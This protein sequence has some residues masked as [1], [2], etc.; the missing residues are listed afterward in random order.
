M[1]GGRLSAG[2]VGYRIGGILPFPS[3]RRSLEIVTPSLQVLLVMPSETDYS[4]ISKLPIALR[5][6]ASFDDAFNRK[7]VGFKYSR[8]PVISATTTPAI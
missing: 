5:S 3:C 1:S 6:V 2:C 4:Q 8:R 7:I